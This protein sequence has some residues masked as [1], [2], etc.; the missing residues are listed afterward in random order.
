MFPDANFRQFSL[1]RGHPYLP[2]P[3]WIA[4]KKAAINPQNKNDEEC[5]KWAVITAL[6]HEETGNNSQQMSELGRFDC[7]YELALPELPI[8]LD[9]I[10]I[11][12][13][14]NDVFV[15]VLAIGGGKEKLYIL[16]KSKF[17]D[18]GAAELRVS[19]RR[20]TSL[21]P[22]DQEEKRHYATIKNLSRL[23]RSSKNSHGYQ[24]HFCPNCLQGFHS[25]ESRNKHYEYCV[26]NEVVRIDMPEENSFMKFLSGQYQFKVPIAIY[27]DF[28]MILQGLEE[29]GHRVT[30]TGSA[31]RSS[32]K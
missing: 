18:Q 32:M 29:E 3:E 27:A 30:E 17:H 26:D 23:L 12:E 20:T 24:Q 31:M 13:W 4:S 6:H 7:N 10:D 5:F 9:E 8:A 14:K 1:T 28:E 21:L 22:I 11:L 16:R 25:K 15:N 2:L 19:P